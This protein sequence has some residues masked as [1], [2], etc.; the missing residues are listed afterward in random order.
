[1][2]ALMVQTADA[3]FTYS[4]VVADNDGERSAEEVAASFSGS[5]PVE[6][7]YCWEPERNIALARNKAIENASGDFIAFID[8]DEFPVADWLVRLVAANKEYE[9]AGVLGPVRPHFEEAPP[10]WIIKGRFCERPEHPTGTVMPWTECRTGNVL[11]RRTIFE[12]IGEPFN[13]EF[14]TGGE[15]KDF[16]LRMNE[17]GHVFI[18]CNEAIAYET[19]PPSRWTRSYMLKRALLRG[20]N[21]LKI[22]SGRVGS[23]AKSVAAIPLYSLV[24][25]V[26]FCCGGHCFMKYLIKMCDHVG[27]LLALLRLNPVNE[28]QM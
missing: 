28:R 8:D 22:S 10:A 19:V 16:F 20:R 18:W 15:D 27:R 2:E 5:A 1:L 6:I 4:I 25:P 9:S 3:G 14:G 21:T 13:R 7:V 26:A 23:L 24:L 11:L 12:E 17:R